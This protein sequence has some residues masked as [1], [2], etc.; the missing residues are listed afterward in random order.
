[1][2]RCK[3][4][5]Y[6]RN[7]NRWKD[8]IFH[9]VDVYID[10]LVPYKLVQHKN[11]C[12]ICNSQL[13]TRI[14]LKSR[15]LSFILRLKKKNLKFFLFKLFN[16]LQKA[17]DAGGE[18]YL[19][20]CLLCHRNGSPAHL[21]CLLLL[22]VC[23]CSWCLATCCCPGLGAVLPCPGLHYLRLGCSYCNTATPLCNQV[24]RP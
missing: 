10:G 18:H 24:Q 3:I 21:R 8:K 13:F 6:G 7:K 9:F 15:S 20:S 19:P 16:I 22:F 23:S 1:M 4:K 14:R 2:A 5:R 17:A 12:A 11:V